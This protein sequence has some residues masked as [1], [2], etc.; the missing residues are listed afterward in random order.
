[1]TITH[2]KEKSKSNKIANAF[3]KFFASVYATNK[4]SYKITCESKNFTNISINLKLI[5]GVDY[6]EVIK[7]G[8]PKKKAAGSGSM[9]PYVHRASSE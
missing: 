7:K 2:S 6:E 1:M 8:K 4:P 9:P 5:M 3:T